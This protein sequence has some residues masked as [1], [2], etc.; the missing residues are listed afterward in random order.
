[1]SVNAQM[2]VVGLGSQERYRR[3]ERRVSRV[4]IEE[5]RDTMESSLQKELERRKKGVWRD[6]EWGESNKSQP[7]TSW[8]IGMGASKDEIRQ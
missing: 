5:E 3:E 7:T 8:R 2:I 1:M 4:E 6:W